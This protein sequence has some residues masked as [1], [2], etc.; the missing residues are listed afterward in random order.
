M[1]IESHSDTIKQNFICSLFSFLLD[2][3][4]FFSY[5]LCL[6]LSFL[7]FSCLFL[8][9]RLFSCSKSS[10]VATDLY[11]QDAALE[12]KSFFSNKMLKCILSSQILNSP[13][14]S[15]ICFN[16]CVDSASNF[17]L[18][19][20][21]IAP[22]YVVSVNK[23]RCNTL[24]FDIILIFYPDILFAFTFIIMILTINYA[25]YCIS[26]KIFRYRASELNNITVP[27]IHD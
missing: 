20:N 18:Y 10:Q 13:N 26:V 22:L 12:Q 21:I 6:S 4:L 2:S 27:V 19:D 24:L 16:C 15:M 17:K 1:V 7:V 11:S 8:S 5:Q 3:C 23:V 14:F 25:H 9:S